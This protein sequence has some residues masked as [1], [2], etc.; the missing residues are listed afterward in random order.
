M[1]NERYEDA[2]ELLQRARAS[3][4]GDHRLTEL[5]AFGLASK[6]EFEQ[7]AEIYKLAEDQIIAQKSTPVLKTFHTSA[8]VAHQLSGNI[9]DAVR[10]LT[11][12]VELNPSAVNDYI[13][14]A[15]RGRQGSQRLKTSI[16]VLKLIP[17]ELLE[18]RA[19]Q[20]MLGLLGLNAEDFTLAVESFQNA[21][22]IA[23]Q[24]G[25]LNELD[26]QFYFW[27]GSA[28]ERNKDYDRA[29]EYFMKAL[30]IQP[31]HADSLNY[32]AYMN[33][34]RGVKLQEG[35]AQV[36]LALAVDP[37][38]P[39]YIDTRGWIYY[40]LGEYEKALEDIAYA[41]EKLPDDATIADHLGDIHLALDNEEQAI[42]WWTKA[43]TLEPTNQAIKEKLIAHGQSIEDIPVLMP[44]VSE[45]DEEDAAE[46]EQIIPASEG[47]QSEDKDF[48]SDEDGMLEITPETNEELEP[49]RD[50]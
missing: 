25:D 39:A 7:A 19:T 17:N 26:V 4:P 40:K 41:A 35:L 48:D 16:D 15:L 43:Y 27:T 23:Q 50:E 22:S 44:T 9:D 2:I 12:G 8:A 47:D 11:R 24:T 29:E 6:K 18:S 46:D 31:D 36:G 30:E 38:N 37:E 33:A 34:E 45:E 21:E 1:M 10:M 28:L 5:L 3:V 13:S 14:Y 42:Q 20:T 49:V 32:V